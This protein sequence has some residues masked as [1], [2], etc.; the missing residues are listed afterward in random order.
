MLWG[1]WALI[2]FSWQIWKKKIGSIQIIFQ[3]FM[4]CIY[5]AFFDLVTNAL[6]FIAVTTFNQ[7]FGNYIS[8][9]GLPFLAL[10]VRY[11]LKNKLTKYEFWGNVITVVGSLFTIILGTANYFGTVYKDG[12]QSYNLYGLEPIPFFF[13]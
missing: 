3:K 11:F 4:Q 13:F 6:L 7:I 8:T 9:L 2:Y 12:Q 10:L 5:A 1:I